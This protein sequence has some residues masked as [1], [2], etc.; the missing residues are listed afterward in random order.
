MVQPS[1]FEDPKCLENVYK[2]HNPLYGLKQAPRAWFDKLQ[3]ALAL[4]CFQSSKSG[5]T[6]FVRITIAHSTFILVYVESIL[7][8]GNDSQVITNLITNL[9]KEFA[10]KD[11]GLVNYF[12][13][14]QVT[15]TSYGLHLSQMKYFID[16]LAQAKMRFAKGFTF[17]MNGGQTLIAFGSDVIVYPQLYISIARA[18]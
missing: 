7:V 11:L 4:F 12:L 6:L 14:F 18:L 17:L 13:G 2:L 8:T 16:I 15:H 3:F 5:Q 10:L 9:Y 1:R